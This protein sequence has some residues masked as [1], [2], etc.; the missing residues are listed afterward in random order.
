MFTADLLFRFENLINIF[1]HHYCRDNVIFDSNKPL[2]Y[3]DIF[4]LQFFEYDED[5]YIL[6]LE[7]RN[8]YFVVWELGDCAIDY[9]YCNT[10]PL[11]FYRCDY[12]NQILLRRNKD[13]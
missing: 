12:I 11:N 10:Y 7:V 1:I 6:F 13:E 9:S 3:S 8:T 5:K 4:I 2:S